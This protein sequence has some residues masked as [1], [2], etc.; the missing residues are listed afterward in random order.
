MEAAQDENIL[1]CFIEQQET[2]ILSMASRVTGHF[3][4]KSDDEWSVALSAFVE[5]VKDYDLKR[6]SFF[7]FAK[8]VIERRL[9]DYI[10]QQKKY[11]NEITVNPVLF[12]SD[13]A[14]DENETDHIGYAVTKKSLESHKQESLAFEINAVNEILMDYGFAFY[15]LIKS[16]PKAAKTKTACVKII[17]Y[18][19]GDPMVTRVLED[20]KL[21]PVK[22]IENNTKVPRKIIERH[23]KYIIAAIVILS[24]EY[25]ELAEYLRTIREEMKR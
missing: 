17:S 1:N 21:L 9:I 22:I 6:G 23:R 20:T 25:Q 8:M 2:V 10:R 12:D 11:R 13:T 19:L 18:C 3:V 4:T 24:G 14:P 16:S 5:A 15:D 7:N